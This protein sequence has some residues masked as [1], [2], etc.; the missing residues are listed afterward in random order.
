M[1]IEERKQLFHIELI[2]VGIDYRQAEK[3]A[4]LLSESLP[5]EQLTQAEQQLIQVV[6]TQWLKY[7]KRMAF[8][9]Q[10]INQIQANSF[11][12]AGMS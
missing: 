3:A 6:C 11:T 8:I 9:S 1:S 5:N 7:R 4:E 12:Y 2:K 10:V